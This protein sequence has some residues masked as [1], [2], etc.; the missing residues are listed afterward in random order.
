[1]AT[2]PDRYAALR[3]TEREAQKGDA[4]P[5]PQTVQPGATGQDVPNDHAAP[6]AQPQPALKPPTLPTSLPRQ[7]LKWDML[8]GRIFQ[9]QSAREWHA[10]ANA[11]AKERFD[12]RQQGQQQSDP[13]Q[14]TPPNQEQPRTYEDLKNEH[15]KIL[16]AQTPSN[17]QPKEPAKE[18]DSKKPPLTFNW[19]RDQGLEQER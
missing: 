18:P 8:P 17:E 3:G 9:E 4:G 14:Q 15:A 13:S 10:Q 6:Q 7:P 12:A 19:D 16:K 11:I 1:M 5:S 2:G